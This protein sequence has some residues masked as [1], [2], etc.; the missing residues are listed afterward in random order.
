MNAV[1]SHPV[2]QIFINV[3]SALIRIVTFLANPLVKR[4]EIVLRLSI[5]SEHRN[6][7]H[8]I[9]SN[10]SGEDRRGLD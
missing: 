4:R 7:Q 5:V 6:I 2:F 9:R 8:Y 10:L 3:H 1:K